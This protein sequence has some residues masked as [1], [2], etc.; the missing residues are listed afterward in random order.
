MSPGGGG[1]T[2]PV[3]IFRYVLLEV[4]LGYSARPSPSSHS[5]STAASSMAGPYWGGAQR[6]PDRVAATTFEK[7]I[8]LPSASTVSVA[9][10]ALGRLRIQPN[11]LVRRETG[12]NND[13]QAR[14]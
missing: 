14:S 3:R 12:P 13:R 5:A 6:A 2:S 10:A 1:L 8:P 7:S 4:A 9:D 11:T